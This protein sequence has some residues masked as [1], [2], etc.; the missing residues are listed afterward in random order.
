[1]IYF[2]EEPSTG[3][4]YVGINGV[5]YTWMGDRWSG[6]NALETGRA[7]FFVEGGDS[8]FEYNEQRDAEL[9]GGNSQANESIEVNIV[10]CTEQ[11]AQLRITYELLGVTGQPIGETGVI[12]SQP[13][14][15]TYDDT[16][17][18][19]DTNTQYGV[20]FARRLHSSG[21]DTDCSDAI[22][23]TDIVDGVYAQFAPA[24]FLQNSTV[25]YRAYA[26]YGQGEMYYSPIRTI[27][28]NYVPCFVAGTQITLADGSKK[29]IE[30]ITYADDLLVW[31]FDAGKQSSAKPL[32]IKR[33]QTTPE[34]NH[35]RFEDG[36][37]LK[38]LQVSQGHRVFSADTNQF[39][40]VGLLP[41]GTNVVKAD[42]TTTQL[43][44]IEHVRATGLV[45]YHNIFTDYHMN[46]YAND[47]LTSTGFNNLYPINDM[48][49][50]KEHREA[51]TYTGIGDHW[52]SGLRLAENTTTDVADM[53]RHLTMLDSL[54]LGK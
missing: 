35:A 4:V 28:L 49:F 40:F 53:A 17:E 3:Q 51:R 16:G 24:N 48:K 50:T 30:D 43:A 25:E 39:E 23:T 18:Y 13:G 11:Y 7:D 27:H 2:P 37:E 12:V 31:D 9:D 33:P 41:A 52:I 44:S 10:S 29:S 1:M 46:L 21:Y 20:R 45:S 47:V 5:S 19:C 26:I 8:A 54:K 6:T 36:T 32:W 14:Y 34:Y 42:G 15:C 38:T 22:I